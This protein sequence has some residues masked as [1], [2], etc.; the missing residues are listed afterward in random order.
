MLQ[1]D[2]KVIL[3]NVA[4]VIGVLLVVMFTLIYVASQVG[5]GL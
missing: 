2:D 3:T 5:A 1:G 4:K